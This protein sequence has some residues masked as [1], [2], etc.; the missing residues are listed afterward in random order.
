MNRFTQA[1]QAAYAA[2]DARDRASV[3]Y[4]RRQLMGPAGDDARPEVSHVA[5]SF[6]QMAAVLGGEL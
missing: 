1:R 3:S 5:A 6:E 4:A 2:A